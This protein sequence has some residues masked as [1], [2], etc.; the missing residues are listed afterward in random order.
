MDKEIS[1]E[2]RRRARRKRIIIASAAAAAFIVVICYLTTL[3]GRTVNSRDIRLAS[4]D[5]GTIDA[6]ISATGQ[7]VPAF[8]QTIT[9]PIASRIME[10]YARS[11]DTLSAGTPLLLLDLEQTRGELDALTSQRRIKEL[12]MERSRVDLATRL[13]D[14][15]MQVKVK[16]MTVSRLAADLVNERRL[17]SL[18][19]GT[20]EKI[21]QAQL[22]Y[23]TGVLELAQLRKQ[24]E[25]SRRAADASLDV[26]RLDI[27]I[28]SAT[29]AD[30]QRTL[31]ESKLLSPRAATL[32]FIVD[33]IGRQVGAGERLAVIAD[34][35]HFKVEGQIADKYAND[36]T[37]GQR[38]VVV[39]GKSKIDGVVTTIR[40]SSAGGVVS[41]SVSLPDD[42]G[43]RLRPGLRTD[44]YVMTD[45][46][47]DCTRI[48]R[49]GYYQGPG[50][51]DLWIATDGATR[52]ERRE[53]TLGEG[54]TEYVEVK[55]GIAP[56]EEVAIVVPS[57]IPSAAKKLKIKR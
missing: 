30:K 25:G 28:A 26:N 1:P 50:R 15:E 10:V 47:D 19:S 13:S 3:G 31:D 55:E 12:E 11:G 37:V 5:R 42:A 51:Y 45:V 16:E 22:A 41:F 36:M 18:G 43:S 21:R 56:G 20:G 7:V 33:E 8:E 32:T 29:I 24:L 14:L 57:D 2:I 46:K 38:V 44:L 54:G 53:V 35:E 17:D 40:P 6:A 4:A 27:S 49:S 48:P 39:S 52:L 34:L 23:D 9:S